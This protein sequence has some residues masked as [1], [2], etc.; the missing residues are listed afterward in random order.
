M[1]FALREMFFEKRNRLCG[2][3]EFGWR[4]IAECF[5][6]LFL[7]VHLDHL[8]IIFFCGPLLP[9]K[10]CLFICFL[11]QFE[12]KTYFERNSEFGRSHHLLI[13]RSS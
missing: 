13:R 6:S 1:R 3:Y 8:L 10:F 5:F 7:F 2:H 4:G 11:D 9:I 12:G